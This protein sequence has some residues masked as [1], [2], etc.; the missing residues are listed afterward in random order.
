MLLALREEVRRQKAGGDGDRRDWPLL[1]P[2]H[3]SP[4]E[5]THRH[6]G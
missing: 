6:F 1:I 3:L 2:L 5:E 4:F